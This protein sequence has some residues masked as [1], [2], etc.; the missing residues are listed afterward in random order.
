MILAA[1]STGGV[2]IVLIQNVLLPA[3][4]RRLSEPQIDWLRQAFARHPA[5]VL[6]AIAVI[7]TLLGV[8]VLL[9]VLWAGRP[10]TPRSQ[11]HPMS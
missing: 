3:V 9:A 8:P 1:G 2:L 5:W 7:A 11:D 4:A 6:A 10:R